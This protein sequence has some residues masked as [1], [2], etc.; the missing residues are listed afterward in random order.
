M[1][2]FVSFVMATVLCIGMTTAV[3]A[4]PSADTGTVS[5]DVDNTP[6]VDIVDKVLDELIDETATAE[7]NV[8]N[9]V[10]ALKDGTLDAKNLA[11]AMMDEK[12]SEDIVDLE[13]QLNLENAIEEAYIHDEVKAVVSSIAIELGGEVNVASMN[14]TSLQ[15]GVLPVT[16]A[17][18]VTAVVFEGTTVQVNIELAV[19]GAIVQPDFPL[20]IKMAV[21]AGVK[22]DSTLRIVHFHNGSQDVVTPV[23][24]GD[25]TISF[26]VQGFSTFAFGNEKAEEPPKTDEEPPTYYAPVEE[27]VSPKTADVS[28]MLVVAVVALVGAVVTTRKVRVN[29]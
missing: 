28:L 27:A 15:L 6:V 21:P 7:E 24:N 25:G 22:A 23:I 17:E 13:A 20:V 14:A 18:T 4:A 5:P 12:V 8:Q 26:S 2:K 9:L 1:K 29:R 19:D 16:Q 11:K 3:M 10:N